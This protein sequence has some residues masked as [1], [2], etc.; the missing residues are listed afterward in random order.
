[1]GKTFAKTILEFTN[2]KIQKQVQTNIENFYKAGG[3]IQPF[4]VEKKALG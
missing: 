1:M 2:H 3:M 4:Q